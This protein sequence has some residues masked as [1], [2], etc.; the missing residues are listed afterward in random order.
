MGK[1]TKI[2][3]NNEGICGPTI[4]GNFEQSQMQKRLSES[5]RRGGTNLNGQ[6]PLKRDESLLSM[7][8]KTGLQSTEESIH[9]LNLEF[10]SSLSVL[11]MFT[12]N[13][14]HETLKRFSSPTFKK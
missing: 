7:T 9:G 6:N 13:T 14:K 4:L 12:N 11:V 3:P 2:E 8:P 5:R 1:P 10:D